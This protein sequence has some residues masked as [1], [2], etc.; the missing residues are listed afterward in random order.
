MSRDLGVQAV[1]NR[2]GAQKTLVRALTRARRRCSR[3]AWKTGRLLTRLAGGWYATHCSGAVTSAMAV[4]GPQRDE[5]ERSEMSDET[6]AT[7]HGPVFRLMYRSH[8]LIGEQERTTQLGAIFTRA[9]ANNRAQDITGA[10]MITEDAF[11]QVLE[12]AED[13]VRALYAQ[14][15]E[16]DR[17]DHVRILEEQEVAERI[18]GRWAMAKVAE[19]GGPDIRLLSNAGRQAIVTAPADPSITPAQEAVLAVMREALALDAAGS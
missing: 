5:D 3:G 1:Q 4:T 16:D 14:I 10:L 15:A 12:G 7:S 11:V 17:H 19:T 13:P 8:S 18:F 2:L 9:R 6:A